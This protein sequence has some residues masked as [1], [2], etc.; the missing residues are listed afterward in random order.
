MKCMVVV[1]VIAK[2]VN[3]NGKANQKQK[4]MKKNLAQSKDEW[5]RSEIDDGIHY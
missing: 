2:I 4:K 5:K 1:S 3:W